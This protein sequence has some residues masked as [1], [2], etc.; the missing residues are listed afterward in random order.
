MTMDVSCARGQ[1]VKS[2]PAQR[3][4]G[5]KGSTES[6]SAPKTYVSIRGRARISG[7]ISIH[8]APARGFAPTRRMSTREGRR[9]GT[10][11]R[12]DG[13][14]DVCRTMDARREGGME[15]WKN[16]TRV[17]VGRRRDSN[18]ED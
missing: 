10:T 1:G 18:G 12:N 8:L 9:E 4:A 13:W 14:M 16:W 11:T 15:E 17:V 3:A 7:V 6:G 2:A 5:Y